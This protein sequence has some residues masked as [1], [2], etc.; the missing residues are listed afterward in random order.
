MK[1]RLWSTNLGIVVYMGIIVA[2][3]V[4]SIF[5]ISAAVTPTTVVESQSA[6]YQGQESLVTYLKSVIETEPTA[7]LA[8][9]TRSSSATSQMVQGQ[10][11]RYSDQYVCLT[12][13]ASSWVSCVAY[14]DILY[15]EVSP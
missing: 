11:S 2:T 9:I 12:S 14:P 15:F 3:L 7:S 13:A 8:I 6:L 5:L 10:V 1:E 4:A